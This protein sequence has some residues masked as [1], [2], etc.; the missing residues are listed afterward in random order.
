M[1]LSS[2]R[3]QGFIDWRWSFDQA[4]YVVGPSDSIS[5]SATVFLR[6]EAPGPIT[7]PASIIFQGT[8]FAL[9]NMQLGDPRLADVNI[10]PGGSFRFT[11]G[12][13]TPKSP[14][15]PGTYRNSPDQP[16]LQ[17][18]NVGWR[19]SDSPL[20]IHVVPEPSPLALASL[21][22]VLVAVKYFARR[23]VRFIQ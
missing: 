20:V 17:F 21:G 7:G 2:S 23:P 4:E 16:L 8:L 22:F 6:P 12:R 15:A 13:L 18:D 1:A 5:L 19:I 9:Y 10:P 3:A 11:F 14:I